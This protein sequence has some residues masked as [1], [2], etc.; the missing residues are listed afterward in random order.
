MSLKIK[1]SV[2]S[3]IDRS[4]IDYLNA[5]NIGFDTSYMGQTKRDN[6][7][8]DSWSFTLYKLDQYNFKR[9]I[10]Q[11]SY[12]TGLGHRQIKNKGQWNEQITINK[13]TITGLLSCL[14][15]D[16][17]ACNMSFCEWSDELGYDNDS[18]KAREIYDECQK[19]SDKLRKVFSNQQIQKIQEL[20]QDY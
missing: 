2:F 17:T 10:Q 20:T 7:N 13:P 5:Q 4:V 11:F 12:F 14:I 8:C 18:I 3:D 16:S 19:Q 15:L 6:W 1:D 9:N